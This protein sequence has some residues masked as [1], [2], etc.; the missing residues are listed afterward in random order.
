MLSYFI[1]Q[2]IITN[3]HLQLTKD[4]AKNMLET[5]KFS[6]AQVAPLPDISS[7]TMKKE[8]TTIDLTSKQL[9]Q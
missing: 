6:G 3:S 8:S 5:N 4:E 1:I 7:T 9:D 2:E